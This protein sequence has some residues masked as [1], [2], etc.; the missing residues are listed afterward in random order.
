VRHYKSKYDPTWQPRFV[1]AP[2]KWA[3]PRLMADAGLLSS[4]G[5]AGL[6]KRPKKNG[7]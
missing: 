1:A 6:A 5:V 3:I 4:G 2:R 7:D